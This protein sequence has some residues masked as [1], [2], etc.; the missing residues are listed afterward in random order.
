MGLPQLT[1]VNDNVMQIISDV[2]HQQ[3]LQI[4]HSKKVEEV[5]WVSHLGQISE[6]AGK[7]EVKF[8]G[9]VVGDNPGEDRVLV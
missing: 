1:E 7:G 4:Y 5:V 6:V 9:V 8:L 2:Y 3:L